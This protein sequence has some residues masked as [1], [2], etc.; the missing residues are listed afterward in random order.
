MSD[1]P[2]ADQ[3]SE[4]NADERR[5]VE[6]TALAGSPIPL[7]VA[8]ALGEWSESEL[9]DVGD[10][11]STAGLVNQSAEG[12]VATDNAAEIVEGMGEM[13]TA[14]TAGAVADAFQATGA[15]AGVVGP[16]LAAAARWSDALAPLAE[17]GLGAV[18]RGHMGEA[19]PLLEQAIRAADETA[20]DD[21]ALR[22]RLHLARAQAFR[23]MGRSGE[24][25][26]DA[27][28]ASRHAEGALLTEAFEWR[29]RLAD[30]QQL[31]QDADGYLAAAQLT[32]VDDPA[33]L[34][35]LHSLRS[36]T[37]GRIG[38]PNEAE[39]SHA[40]A[41]ALLER[42]GSDEDRAQATYDEAWVAFDQG[43]AQDAA[44]KFA[45]LAER[46][47]DQQAAQLADR[48]VW[49]ARSLFAA[50]KP[51][52]AEETRRRAM[53]R[54]EEV[55]AFG[56]VF[57]GHMALAEGAGMYGAWDESLRGA[58]DM[59]EV[60]LSTLPA[61]ENAAR[62][63]RARALNGLGRHDE[64]KEEIIAAL[65]ATPKGINGWRWRN[66]C[67]A[68]QWR[69][70]VDAGGKW[71]DLAPADL[72]E[73]LLAARF[74]S[75]AV[76][77]LGDRVKH[78]KDPELG[79][80]A[81]A[82][83]L[84]VGQPAEAARALATTKFW[85]EP[86]GVAAAHAIRN[87]TVPDEW[88][89]AWAAVPGVA[90]AL[91]APE[92]ADATDAVQAMQADLDAVF[93]EA[94]LEVEDRRLSPAQRRAAGL[95]IKE[96]RQP[97][98]RRRLA[99]F[100]SAAALVVVAGT[101]GALAATVFAPDP[102]F[103]IPTSIVTVTVPGQEAPKT[104]EE[105]QLQWPDI[106]GFGASQ[107]AFHGEL[108]NRGFNGDRDGVSSR[109]GSPN[110]DGYY[111]KF[112]TNDRIDGSP[113]VRG[114]T[115]YIGSA[116]ET[117]YTIDIKTGRAE[118]TADAGGPIT[119][120]PSFAFAPL[121]ESVE[122]GGG[123]N[124]NVLFFASED[125]TVYGYR[126]RTGAELWENRAG[127]SVTAPLLSVDSRVFVPSED[128][129]LYA[130]EQIPPGNLSWVYPPLEE[131]PLGPLTAAPL[132]QDGT[133]IIVSED[134]T[135]AGIDGATGEQVCRNTINIAIGAAPSI[136]D[137]VAYLAASGSFYEF[138]PTTCQ[139]LNSQ[140]YGEFPVYASPVVVDNIAYIT[141]GPS[142]LAF[143]IDTA[144]FEWRFR[145]AA[146]IRSS[147][148][149]AGD[150]IYFGSDDNNVYAVN[151]EDGTER[152][153]FQTEGEVRSSPAVGDGVIYVGSR[154]GFLYAI[155]GAGDGS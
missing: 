152:W 81:A 150:V 51:A 148:T 125:G 78:E 133:V 38:Y 12:F 73:E 110:L 131:D 155:G 149:V 15:D 83:A 8:V 29:A 2:I 146:T 31:S 36:R 153:R 21:R 104:V 45:A 121:G 100:A 96:P 37:L 26:A 88:A 64:A 126:T 42:H 41:R 50:G 132:Y 135:Y 122:E 39:A 134:G 53:A 103:D 60:V 57:L 139:L 75:Q 154:D 99:T 85:S 95:R 118:W 5:L 130:F 65:A 34:G 108:D 46:L 22:A 69:I 68:L 101:A 27:A 128:G 124:E 74:Y 55:G 116:N 20:S 72:T 112:P 113:S 84:R 80:S 52:E 93:A 47:T 61:W 145:T 105:T 115:V 54:A 35:T 62:Y 18:S 17:A 24:A 25:V 91:A 120:S 28:E 58:D 77:L 137:N 142:M 40:K 19:V 144:L 7:T 23:L 3:I 44:D 11:L 114:E 127:G 79:R 13:R 140:L 66:R 123:G 136:V 4:L 76:E 6:A 87:I 147:P 10:R 63:L 151:L 30:D 43:R 109:A 92:V 143:N 94:G 89:E 9:L 119:S 67:R 32:A 49:L 70:D 82:L 1:R 90:T 16:L 86:E 56:P 141:D 48:E 71:D 111:W 102:V 59:L 98:R 97:R 107:W 138:R 117:F 14:A 33:R 106:A 129:R